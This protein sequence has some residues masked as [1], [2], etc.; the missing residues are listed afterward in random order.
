MRGRHIDFLAA[1]SALLLLFRYAWSAELC[2]DFSLALEE[3]L[4]M[5]LIS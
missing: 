1:L 5:T 3:R 2:L 4:T